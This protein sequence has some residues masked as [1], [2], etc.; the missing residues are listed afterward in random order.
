M[1]KLKNL[2]NDNFDNTKENKNE[3]DDDIDISDILGNPFDDSPKTEPTQ[4]LLTTVTTKRGKKV[5]MPRSWTMDRYVSKILSFLKFS[6]LASLGITGISGAGKTV[7][8][9]T[10][11]HTLHQQDPSFVIKWFSR[12][13]VLNM[14]KVLGTMPKNRNIVIIMDDISFLTDL[15]TKTEKAETGNL[16]A[17]MRHTFFGPDSKV[18]LINL[19]HYSYSSEKK[20]AFR[21]TSFQLNIGISGNELDNM[22][23]THGKYTLKNYARIWRQAV[24]NGGFKYQLDGYADKS[25]FYE[26]KDY[27]PILCN[28]VNWSHLLMVEELSCNI[29]NKDKWNEEEESPISEEAF[30]DMLKYPKVQ[31]RNA[32]KYFAYLRTGDIMFLNA[33]QR[34]LFRHISKAYEHCDFDLKKIIGLLDGEMKYHR[35]ER[36]NITD[37]DKKITKTLDKIIEK[38]K[39]KEEKNWLNDYTEIKLPE[40]K[41]FMYDEN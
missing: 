20:L 41:D 38:S 31:L 39:D 10:I 35:A 13:D 37:D 4:S 18:L 3:T 7:T 21:S 14:E 8:C 5:I 30:I 19:N 29:C 11:L 12:H 40:K 26:M 15:L 34:K 17:T 1:V 23:Q 25:V 9:K 32:F 16:M 36:K 2:D 27:R 22:K 24:L 33:T 28:E 6:K